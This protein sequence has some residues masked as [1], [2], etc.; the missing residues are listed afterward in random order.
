MHQTLRDFFCAIQGGAS[1]FTSFV[2]AWS[3]LNDTVQTNPDSLEEETLH[4]LHNSASII[5][6]VA[7]DIMQLQL[8]SEKIGQEVMAD[9]SKIILQDMADLNI[10]DE[11]SNTRRLKGSLL[12]STPTYVKP[13]YK[14][15]LSNLHNPY[16]SKE[17]KSD[18]SRRT[19]SPVKDIDAWFV[20]VRKR[21]GWNK[22]RKTI[23]ANKQEKI[24][25]AATHYFK[26]KPS[27]FSDDPTA[28][29]ISEMDPYDAH[30]RHFAAIA[31]IAL[32]LYADKFP[33]I[34]TSMSFNRLGEHPASAVALQDAK[35]TF[36][37]R[38]QP[39]AQSPQA[40]GDN[41]HPY[42]TPEPS[43]PSYL[44]EEPSTPFALSESQTT[45][46]AAAVTRKRRQSLSD[47]CDLDTDD[48]WT[49]PSKRFRL[50]LGQEV[51][52]ATDIVSCLPS[53]SHTNDPTEDT[54]EKDTTRPLVVTE[55]P[56]TPFQT[57]CL[58]RRRSVSDEE[59]R[60]PAKYLHTG[61]ASEVVVNEC[62]IPSTPSLLRRKRRLS[63]GENQR[64]SKR[65]HNALA[66]PRLQTVSDPFPMN[67]PWLGEPF[68]I[69]SQDSG[70]LEKEP[71]EIPSSVHLEDP[72]SLT[73]PLDVCHG[74]YDVSATEICPEEYLSYFVNVVP[75]LCQDTLQ[76]PS[77]NII[78]STPNFPDFN[79]MLSG[80]ECDLSLPTQ[81]TSMSED[82]SHWF[83]S[84][85]SDSFCD[86]SNLSDS[87]P[88]KTAI[89][90]AAYA[91]SL[92]AKRAR[93][94]A[95]REQVSQLEGQ[96][97]E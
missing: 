11:H 33:E 57:P 53:P 70:I 15:L 74:Q 63:D 9:V 46:A 25:A 51:A 34:V 67:K 17:V 66:Q 7:A 32:S 87:T 16:P 10:N 37:G 72:I 36:K 28:S 82:L 31:N 91:D 3:S 35:T 47:S 22:L 8:E 41:T 27:S 29:L 64:P 77:S 61:T 59:T 85:Q 1:S 45:T 79:G 21:I 86:P 75:S 60:G 49:H 24:I 13:A 19:R 39:I 73:G 2:K 43:P 83:T 56:P 44:S 50:D 62:P 84:M 6:I 12:R 38:F 76:N 52:F 95:L 42:P 93:L 89:N 81:F 88:S 30:H 40:V 65:P 68:E 97:A 92:D 54:L 20:D 69:P 58:K 26:P 55:V 4:A 71:M 48:N 78:I 96:L 14:W 94:Q 5:G 23:F 90:Y 80:P 18:I